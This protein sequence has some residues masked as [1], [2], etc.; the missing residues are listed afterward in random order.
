VNYKIVTKALHVT[1]E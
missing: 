1:A